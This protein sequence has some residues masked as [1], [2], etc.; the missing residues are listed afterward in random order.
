M[1]YKFWMNCHFDNCLHLAST[2]DPYRDRDV[3]IYALPGEFDVV[4]VSDGTDAWIAPVSANPFIGQGVNIKAIL[5]SVRD[6][7]FRSAAA[8]GVTRRRIIV[9][10]PEP[11]PSRR[12]IVA[13]ESTPRRR[14]ING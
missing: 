10:Q 5:G 2:R 12:V 7:T 8:T 4:G 3:R 6:G 11:S 14:I 13:E 1:S 9:Q